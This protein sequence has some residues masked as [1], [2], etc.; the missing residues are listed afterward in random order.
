MS[1]PAMNFGEDFH[2]E[3]S[4]SGLRRIDAEDEPEAPSCMR[5]ARR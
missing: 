2:D 3:S 1:A 4:D 5:V